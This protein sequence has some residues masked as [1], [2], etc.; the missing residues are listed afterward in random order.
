MEF[1]GLKVDSE[2]ELQSLVVIVYAEQAGID[3]AP[4]K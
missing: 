4:Y 2:L 3:F 1:H